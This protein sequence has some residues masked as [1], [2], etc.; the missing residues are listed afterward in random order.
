LRF[1]RDKRRC[2]LRTM[3]D[4]KT[5]WEPNPWKRHISIDTCSIEEVKESI[6]IHL[7]SG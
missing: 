3:P 1:M 2:C 6:G 5:L 7:R 4:T